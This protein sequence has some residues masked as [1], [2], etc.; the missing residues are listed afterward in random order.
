[1]NSLIWCQPVPLGLGRLAPQSHPHRAH[2][3]LPEP[4][5]MTL[6][7]PESLHQM[8]WFQNH[9]HNRTPRKN[10][11]GWMTR[12]I[13]IRFLASRMNIWRLPGELPSGW[14][15]LCKHPSFWAYVNIYFI[16]DMLILRVLWMTWSQ[17]SLFLSVCPSC[18]EKRQS[19]SRRLTH[20]PVP[21][22]LSINK[23]DPAYMEWVEMVVT[24]RW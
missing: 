16:R 10:L 12:R 23:I 20:R 18:R 2:L 5:D 22:R 15:K 17:P 3:D 9:R 4:F 6:P 11:D 1:M 19:A 21:S 14:L 7:G 13:L 8:N 24:M